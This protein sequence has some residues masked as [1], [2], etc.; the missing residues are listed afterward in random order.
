MAKSVK[1]WDKI[2]REYSSPEASDAEDEVNIQSV[3][4]NTHRIAEM[5][6]N[7]SGLK[8][9]MRTPPMGMNRLDDIRD[10][11]AASAR[12]VSHRIDAQPD[13][14]ET[15]TSPT[16]EEAAEEEEKRP[17]SPREDST[18]EENHEGV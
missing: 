2:M 4:K 17:P 6:E 3:K 5:F 10:G 13:S 12:E 7:L 18:S 11:L 14:S 16:T 1:D 9:K 8:D 15:S